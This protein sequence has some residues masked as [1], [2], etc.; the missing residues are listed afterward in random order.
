MIRWQ[1]LV[2]PDWKAWSSCTVIF[3]SLFSRFISPSLE[4]VFFEIRDG[5]SAVPCLLM[6]W[7]L[8]LSRYP[9]LQSLQWL[10]EP[11]GA[12]L[13]S[14]TNRTTTERLPHAPR[15]LEE[16]NERRRET[17]KGSSRRCSPLHATYV[18]DGGAE[19][20]GGAASLWWSP[21]LPGPFITAFDVRRPRTKDLR[22]GRKCLFFK[23]PHGTGVNVTRDAD[24]SVTS[25]T[26][27]ADD[28]ELGVSLPN[29]IY[30]IFIQTYLVFND[31]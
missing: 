22:V 15:M 6:E 12:L 14:S 13:I 8:D 30:C 1:L 19:W 18:Q 29:F 24:Q 27:E 31:C 21:T 17:T 25:S 10:P 28:W 16:E 7:V 23:T 2:P 5:M 20:E 26:S 9:T 11:H 3:P 4:R